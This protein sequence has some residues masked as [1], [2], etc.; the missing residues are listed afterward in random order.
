MQLSGF[1]S[2]AFTRHFSLIFNN[3]VVLLKMK[4]DMGDNRKIDILRSLMHPL[5]PFFMGHRVKF[6]GFRKRGMVRFS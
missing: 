6:L 5:S 1:A 2:F 4:C 3:M